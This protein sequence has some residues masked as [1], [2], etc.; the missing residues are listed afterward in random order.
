MKPS[1]KEVQYSYIRFQSPV[2]PGPTLEPVYEFK[3]DTK[4]KK[5]KVDKITRI[6]DTIYLYHGDMVHH[7]PWVNVS[8]ARPISSVHE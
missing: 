7:T 1:N 6:G 2:P 3:L 4:D 8:Y 5:Y